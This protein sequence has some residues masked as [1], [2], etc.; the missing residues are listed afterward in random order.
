[1]KVAMKKAGKVVDQ[2]LSLALL[3]CLLYFIC[4][5][6]YHLVMGYLMPKFV[7]FVNI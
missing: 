1:M 5:M 6:V 2:H 3:L 7:S 4:L